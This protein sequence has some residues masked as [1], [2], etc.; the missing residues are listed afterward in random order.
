MSE[1]DTH[2][3]SHLCSPCTS[4]HA[5]F[6][7]EPH[8]APSLLWPNY[9]LTIV[10]YMLILSPLAISPLLIPEPT[11]LPWELNPEHKI[12]PLL[13]WVSGHS[14][15]INHFC[16]PSLD[17]LFSHSYIP[18]SCLYRLNTVHCSCLSVHPVNLLTSLLPACPW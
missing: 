9:P 2:R 6:L 16:P 10:Q 15:I 8:P 17:P 7:K 18:S 3:Q 4:Y 11:L 13:L 12:I 5:F 14:T 1:T